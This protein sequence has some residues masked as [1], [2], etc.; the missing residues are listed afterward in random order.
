MTKEVKKMQIIK[1]IVA[2]GNSSCVIIPEEIL[3]MMEAIQGDILMMEIIAKKD[4]NGIVTKF[5]GE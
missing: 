2:H 4:T 1:R 3:D 5:D